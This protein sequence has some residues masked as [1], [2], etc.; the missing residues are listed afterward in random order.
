[1]AARGCGIEVDSMEGSHTSSSDR[2]IFACV[3]T[4]V[5][6]AHTFSCAHRI[7]GH[8]DKL[9]AHTSSCT[10]RTSVRLSL[11]QYLSRE[12]WKRARLTEGKQEDKS[13]TSSCT[14]HTSLREGNL[15]SHTFL[16]VHCTS[17][18]EDR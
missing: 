14:H 6:I 8:E 16:C 2:P 4:V 18:G 10:H 3:G 9:L 1:M 7:F 5:G 11:F 12:F 17:Q 15:A 13:R